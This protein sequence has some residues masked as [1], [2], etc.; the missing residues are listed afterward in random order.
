MSLRFP[1]SLPLPSHEPPSCWCGGGGGGA[2]EGAQ[3]LAGE[4]LL[5]PCQTHNTHVISILTPIST[6]G[7]AH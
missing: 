1:P 2:V 5:L 6:S 7:S 4:E 3:R